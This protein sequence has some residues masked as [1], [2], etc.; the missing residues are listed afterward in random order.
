MNLKLLNIILAGTVVGLCFELK[1]KKHNMEQIQYDNTKK[2]YMCDIME[3]WINNKKDDSTMAKYLLNRKINSVAIYGL[4]NI[5]QTLINELCNC[6][7]EIKYGI[8]KNWELY[9]ENFKVISPEETLDEVDAII[10][11][12]IMEF[13]SIKE[14]LSKRTSVPIVSIEEVIDMM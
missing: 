14:R 7:V 1:R 9:C 10:V 6:D 11:T 3:T 13:D 5:G 4:G 8:D 2:K 12:P